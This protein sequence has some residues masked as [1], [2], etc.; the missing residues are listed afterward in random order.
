M[1]EVNKCGDNVPFK[2]NTTQVMTTNRV[3]STE[4][5]VILE[6]IFEKANFR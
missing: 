2:I 4:Q 3:I 6:E 5:H 1:I